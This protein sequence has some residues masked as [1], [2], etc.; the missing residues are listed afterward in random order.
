VPVEPDRCTVWWAT[1]YEPPTAGGILTEGERSRA[2]RLRRPE[3]RT[4]FVTARTLLRLVLAERLDLPPAQVALV[5][6]CPVCGANDHGR[7][8]LDG[9]L[10]RQVSLGVTHRG[11]RV[12]IAVTDGRAVGVDVEVAEDPDDPERAALAAEALCP[13]ELV[14]YRRLP[15]ATRGW[16]VARWW[17]RKE[18]VLKATGD[19]LAL[20]PS[21]LH[22]SRPNAPAALLD[23]I[24]PGPSA[25]PRP[26]VR[27]HDLLP[28]EGYVGCVAALGSRP[29]RVRE[30]DGDEVLRGGGRHPV[31][32]V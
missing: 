31:R 9:G 27:L 16:A 4:R 11:T 13:A 12:G 30:L 23:W 2:A 7:L 10:G 3:D 19:G 20:S 22:V 18:A 26:A 21:Q 14:A 24:E 1:P 8:R 28:G 15:T 32:A 5:A 6:A 29:I 25:G 17:T